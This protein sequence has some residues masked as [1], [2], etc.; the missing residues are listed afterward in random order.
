MQRGLEALH[1]D[2]LAWTH[3]FAYGRVLARHQLTLLEREVLA[4]GIL[5]AM[6]GLDAPLLGHM[7][8]A[9]RLGATP[10][11]LTEVID[12]VRPVARRGGADAARAIDRADLMRGARRRNTAS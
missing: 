7:R 4:V 9:V 11:Q 5:A 8:A 3:A 12:V 10:D 6:G 2:L 1:P